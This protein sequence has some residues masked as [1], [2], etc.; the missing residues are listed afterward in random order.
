[1]SYHRQ[2][3]LI[4]GNDTT[5]SWIPEK[6]ALK[7]KYLKLKDNGEWED[8]WKVEFVGT[9]LP[10]KYVIDRSQDHVHQRKASDI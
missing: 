5:V 9:K 4:K 6:F 2:C 10:T 1:M 8:G 7:G 3:K